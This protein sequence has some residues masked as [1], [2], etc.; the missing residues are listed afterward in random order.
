MAGHRRAMV[1]AV[2][3]EVMALL[4]GDGRV[5]GVDHRLIVVMGAQHGAQVDGVVLA[6]HIYVPVQVSRTRLQL[7]QKLWVSDEPKP[8]AGFGD[9]HI[10]PGPPVLRGMSS[11]V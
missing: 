2:N 7:S 9:A 5:D 6:R 1:L 3:D 11:S 8:T 10:A 4:G